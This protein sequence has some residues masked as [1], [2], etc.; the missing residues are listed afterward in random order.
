MRFITAFCLAAFCAVGLGAQSATTETK[1]KTKIDVK[2]GKDIT[3]TGCLATNPSGGF[4]LTDRRGDQKYAL[5]TED[6]LAKHVGHWMEVKGKAADRGDGKVKIE[7]TT[8]TSGGEKTKVKT[9]LKGDAASMNAPQLLLAITSDTP[10]GA[11]ESFKSGT[12]RDLV[13]RLSPQWTNAGAA[14]EI[15]LFRVTR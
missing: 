14:V 13:S 3:I 2:D 15:E 1:T 6:D 10:L 4:M 7:S 8:G 12:A 5:V 11:I 9:E